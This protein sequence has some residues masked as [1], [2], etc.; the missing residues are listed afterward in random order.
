MLDTFD[1]HGLVIT[2]DDLIN[3]RISEL[4][5]DVIFN[6]DSDFNKYWDKKD[7]EQEITNSEEE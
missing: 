1:G 6:E 3:D 5:F 4:D 2:D 7:K